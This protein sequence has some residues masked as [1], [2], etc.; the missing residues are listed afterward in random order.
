VFLTIAIAVA[1]TVLFMIVARDALKKF[2]VRLFQLALLTQMAIGVAAVAM[3]AGTS[4]NTVL[5]LAAAL[6]AA[7]LLALYAGTKMRGDAE[8]QL[9]ETKGKLD[10]AIAELQRH[11]DNS[12]IRLV[13]EPAQGKPSGK[14]I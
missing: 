2:Y 1:L 13:V 11:K 12:A 6:I 7:A 5:S 4:F 8:K 10:S 14:V 9:A 3:G